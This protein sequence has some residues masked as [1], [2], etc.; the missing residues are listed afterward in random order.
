MD[1]AKIFWY[2]KTAKTQMRAILIARF[3]C[4]SF[5][6]TRIIAAL[7]PDARMFFSTPY[8]NNIITIETSQIIL[9]H[10]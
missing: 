7:T 3:F 4:S 1:K 9:E 8:I 10:V 5:R 2:S 6:I